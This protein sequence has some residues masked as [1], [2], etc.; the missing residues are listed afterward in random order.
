MMKSIRK[1]NHATATHLA[2]NLNPAL[3][4]DLIQLCAAVIS[5]KEARALGLWQSG[6]TQ[7]KLSRLTLAWD[8]ATDQ[9]AQCLIQHG[10]INA[11]ASDDS[12][13]A[14]GP[15][16]DTAQICHLVAQA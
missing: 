5:A 9:L 13:S 16:R 1:T 15:K 3:C 6:I 7:E 10:L 4:E 12:V 11:A 8:D 2:E 14:P